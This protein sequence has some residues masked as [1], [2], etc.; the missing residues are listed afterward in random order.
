M[1]H[2]TPSRTGHA[3]R[4]ILPTA[5]TVRAYDGRTRWD[6]AYWSVHSIAMYQQ[7]TLGEEVGLGSRTKRDRAV[8]NFELLSASTEVALRLA[9]AG[10]HSMMA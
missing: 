8:A 7:E 6:R 5:N 9:S 2:V 4:N 3:G 1:K 10:R